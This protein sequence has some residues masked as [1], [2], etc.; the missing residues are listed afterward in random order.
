MVPLTVVAAAAMGG[1]L[2]A[3][4]VVAAELQEHVRQLR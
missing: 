4:V 1:R 2:I 3:E